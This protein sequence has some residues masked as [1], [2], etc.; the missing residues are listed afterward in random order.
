[1]AHALVE[2][3]ADAIIGHHA[4]NVQPYE[5][6][7]TQRDPARIAPIFYGLGNLASIMS[8]PYNALSLVLNLEIVKGLIDGEEK[9]LLKNFEATPVIQVEERAG[10]LI[11]LR[12]YPLRQLL[13]D[14]AA[15][16]R[17]SYLREASTYADLALGAGWRD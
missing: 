5:L 1:M 12:L 10:D 14:V 3:G 2:S 16:E 4:H 15:R 11:R 17:Q 8:S 9:T 6:Y 13:G 7:R